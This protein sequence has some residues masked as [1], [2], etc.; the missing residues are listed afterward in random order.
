V[1]PAIEKYMGDDGEFIA[2]KDRQEHQTVSSPYLK[3]PP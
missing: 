2:K 3:S 1:Y